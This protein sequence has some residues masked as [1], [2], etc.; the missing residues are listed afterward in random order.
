MNG[1]PRKYVEI[2]RTH[3]LIIAISLGHTHKN[4]SQ[5]I[6]VPLQL[7]NLDLIFF[8]VRYN[9]LEIVTIRNKHLLLFIR[10]MSRI[11]SPPN[12][13]T[14][15]QKQIILDTTNSFQITPPE[16]CLYLCSLNVTLSN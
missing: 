5:F 12:S 1:R 2:S 6:I 4:T 8:Y 9:E 13:G 16:P 7:L 3:L 14:T 10:Q 11:T 15:E